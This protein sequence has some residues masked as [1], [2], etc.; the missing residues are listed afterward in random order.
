MSDV[1][2]TALYPAMIVH[3]TGCSDAAKALASGWARGGSASNVDGSQ[4]FSGPDV[5]SVLASI[6]Q[7]MNDAGDWDDDWTLADFH[8]APC[9]RDASKVKAPKPV[10]PGRCPGSGMPFATDGPR[11]RGGRPLYDACPSCGYWYGTGRGV[12]PAHKMRSSK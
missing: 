5:D 9:V 11:W 4:D 3:R 1:T 7:D 8:V 6:V 12:L 2:L 10:P